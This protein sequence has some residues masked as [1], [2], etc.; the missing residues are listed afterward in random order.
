MVATVSSLERAKGQ[1]ILMNSESAI[2]SAAAA[3]ILLVLFSSPAIGDS[4]SVVYYDRGKG[5]LTVSAN[6]AKIRKLLADISSKTGITIL[7]DPSIE[8]NV[9]IKISSKPVEAALKQI[10]K[11]LSYALIYESGGEDHR[12][13]GVRILPKGKGGSLMDSTDLGDDGTD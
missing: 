4:P 12:L 5:T 10:M 11:G 2:R 9:T 7:I 3:L 8:K 13:T 1:D 6:M